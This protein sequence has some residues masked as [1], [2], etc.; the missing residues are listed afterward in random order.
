MAWT[1]NC[2]VAVEPFAKS[3]QQQDT[4]LKGNML[5]DSAPPP[6][7]YDE[8][9]RASTSQRINIQILAPF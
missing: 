9:V 4:I 6:E 5:E 2:S 7:D 8:H 3:A 1:R